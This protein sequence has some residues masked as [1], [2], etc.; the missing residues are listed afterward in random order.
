MIPRARA[1]PH[2]PPILP[3]KTTLPLIPLP[4]QSKPLNPLHSLLSILQ[5][6]PRLPLPTLPIPKPPATNPPL[7]PPQIISPFDQTIPPP[8]QETTHHTKHT[9]L[10]T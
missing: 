4:L 7:L 6:P 1:P 10:Q 8:L 9:L 3:P 2:L 5:I